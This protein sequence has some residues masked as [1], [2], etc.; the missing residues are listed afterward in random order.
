FNLDSD[1][2]QVPDS[3]ASDASSDEEDEQDPDDPAPSVFAPLHLSLDA[4][5]HI[6][7]RGGSLA[8]G[9]GYRS[10][11]RRL[12]ER[13][14]GIFAREIGVPWAEV[15]EWLRGGRALPQTPV[16]PIDGM[17]DSSSSSP[18]PNTNGNSE[19]PKEMIVGPEAQHVALAPRE[20]PRNQVEKR[21]EHT[22]P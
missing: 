7:S 20:K 3:D 17:M 22:E 14:E 4:Y 9:T 16:C 13:V 5:A 11:A 10:V 21:L 18:T 12:L 1:P 2:T 15:L 8:V 19:S 6:L